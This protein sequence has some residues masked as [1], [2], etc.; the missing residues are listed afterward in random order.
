MKFGASDMD[1]RAG[2]HHVTCLLD[3]PALHSYPT[4]ACIHLSVP[5]SSS[6]KSS[7]YDSACA[8]AGQLGLMSLYESLFGTREVATSQ[9]RTHNLARR[10][11]N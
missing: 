1:G 5:L 7:G 2:W 8:A 11:Q 9:A 3:D 10:F 6:A 4:F